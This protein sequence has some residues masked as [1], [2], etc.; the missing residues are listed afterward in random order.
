MDGSVLASSL[1]ASTVRMSELDGALAHYG[2]KGMKWGIRKKNNSGESKPPP[3]D[4]AKQVAEYK[5]RVKA[6]GTKSL[7]TKE[8]QDLVNR[9][10]LEQQYSKLNSSSRS[11]KL[12]KGHSTVKKILAV[13]KTVQEVHSF[14]RSPLSAALREAFKR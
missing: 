5:S 14:A 10:N 2:I 1:S 3:S 12:D 7:E 11:S 8:L 9:M 6:G 13:G 4:D